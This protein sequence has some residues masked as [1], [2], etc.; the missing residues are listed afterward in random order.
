MSVRSAEGLTAGVEASAGLVEV[1]AGLE[2]AVAP[3]AVAAPVDKRL[4]LGL[5]WELALCELLLWELLL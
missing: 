1:S 5:L 4:Y 2:D 3:P